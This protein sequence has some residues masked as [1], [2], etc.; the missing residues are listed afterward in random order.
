[1]AIKYLYCI[2]LLYDV[3]SRVLE[4]DNIYQV[5]LRIYLP[6]KV[7]FTSVSKLKSMTV[8]LFDFSTE[9]E[10]YFHLYC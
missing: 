9:N 3:T 4:C 2:V 5:D 10:I 8:L 1:M 6:L 7:I